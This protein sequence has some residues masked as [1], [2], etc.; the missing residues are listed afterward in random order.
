MPLF[1]VTNDAFK[2]FLLSVKNSE[3]VSNFNYFTDNFNPLLN[4][5]IGEFLLGFTDF[6]KL[7]DPD[8][9]L[10]K[11]DIETL[12]GIVNDSLAPGDGRIV[13]VEYTYGVSY[14]FFT[15]N[16]TPP[17]ITVD[18]ALITEF[19]GKVKEFKM[20][21]VFSNY[22]IAFRS[23]FGNKKI[24]SLEGRVSYEY[25]LVI[26]PVCSPKIVSGKRNHMLDLEDV[27]LKFQDNFF[28]LAI[29][30]KKSYICNDREHLKGLCEHKDHASINELT[31]FTLDQ[32]NKFQ[33]GV[34]GSIDKMVLT[35]GRDI[36]NA[37]TRGNPVTKVISFVDADNNF[38]ESSFFSSGLT[39][40]GIAF[41][42]NDLVPPPFPVT[43]KSF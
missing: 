42:A 27:F 19:I 41:D 9:K 11:K 4:N 13:S 23:Y 30:T 3:K 39:V 25:S 6:D 2:A 5:A 33:Y 20:S 32:F 22:D 38:L 17:F 21:G 18:Y 14:R 28:A 16:G 24:T 26:I 37:E 1:I 12:V 36:G 40:S 35:F 15:Q 8:Y 29:T 31:Y 34:K 10:P 43:D 7:G